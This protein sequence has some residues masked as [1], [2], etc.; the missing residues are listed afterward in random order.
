[1]R[2]AEHPGTHAQALADVVAGGLS[3]DFAL[4]VYAR[5]VHAA[6]TIE[7]HRF[8]ISI[9]VSNRWGRFKALRAR[10]LDHLGSS[11]RRPVVLI[12]PRR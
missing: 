2:S 1:V 4:A 8:S 10:W 7:T 6:L 9:R 3:H 12:G 11:S 5:A